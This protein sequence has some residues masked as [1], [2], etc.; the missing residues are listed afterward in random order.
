MKKVSI[1]IPCY[2]A[3]LHLG[4]AVQS[5]LDQ[6]YPEL[7]IIIV[8][9]G[10]DDPVTLELL[11]QAVWPRT[12]IIHQSNAGP[13]A[14]RN[15]AVR[16]ASGTYVLPLDADDTIEADYVAKAVAILDNRPEVGVV[17]CRA[18]K[19]GAEVGPWELPAYS[20]N[21]LAIDN[22][23]F[24]T[25]LYRKADWHAIGGYNEKLLH[26]VEDYDFWVKMADLGRD[27]FQLDDYLFNY[28]VQE[29]SR[30]SRFREVSDNVV[31]TYAEIFRANK[32]FYAKHAESIF[33]H[34]FALYSQLADCRERIS[35]LDA[36]RRQ[37]EL[38]RQE[39][40]AQRQQLAD[41]R[42]KNEHLN[43]Q[44]AHW[45]RR[46]GKLDALFSRYSWLTSI[47]RRVKESLRL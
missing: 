11:S 14:A 26:G 4:E 9:D 1:V 35:E 44:L 42:T 25:A 20:V 33:R 2:N 21:E 34:R 15:R 36:C 40:D 31:E 18:K 17:Y 24:V 38:S 32:S 45:R 12:S 3:G 7:E 46:Y 47:A 28:R 43:E 10:S 30:T 22:M 13:A 39:L 37:I 6:T 27:V 16:E 5:A 23:I 19:F 8:D 29:K 41:C